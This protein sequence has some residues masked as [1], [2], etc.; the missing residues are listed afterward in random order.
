[1]TEAARRN[2]KPRRR[3][4]GVPFSAEDVAFTLNSL[5]DLGPKVRW[6]IDVNQA[7]EKATATD[8]N[9]HGC[10]GFQ[11]TAEVFN[12]CEHDVT[13]GYQ[14]AVCLSASNAGTGVLSLVSKAEFASQVNCGLGRSC[15]N[16]SQCS[17][18]YEGFFHFRFLQG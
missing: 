16:Q 17:D 12:S 8:A 18:S 10:A 6:G 4:D 2:A 1:M 3:T 7:V 11:A 5:R 13:V 15:T 14:K 9:S